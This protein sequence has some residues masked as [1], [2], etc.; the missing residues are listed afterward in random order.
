MGAW[1]RGNRWSSE[2]V[3]GARLQLVDSFEVRF[4]RTTG[5]VAVG[6]MEAAE[7][8]VKEAYKQGAGKGFAHRGACVGERVG[9]PRLPLPMPSHVNC[10][11]HFRTFSHTSVQ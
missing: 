9:V 3:N 5:L 2:S 1:G 8:A 10:V 11:A 7:T 4:S 6:N